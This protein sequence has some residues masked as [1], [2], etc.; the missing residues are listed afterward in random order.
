M[1]GQALFPG[2]FTLVSPCNAKLG[3]LSDSSKG[4]NMVLVTVIIPSMN[5]IC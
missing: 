3:S 4:L 2:A 1:V 5:L